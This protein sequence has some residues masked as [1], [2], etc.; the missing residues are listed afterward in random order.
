MMRLSRLADYGV[1]LMTQMARKP[2]LVVNTHDLVEASGLPAATVSKLLATLARHDLLESIR[3]SKGGYLL[4]RPPSAITMEQI[5]TAIDGP[6]S[7]T[8]CVDE[9]GD[10]CGVSSFCVSQTYW[11]RI[12]EAIKDALDQVTLAEIAGSVPAFFAA[13][14]VTA[15]AG[16]QHRKGAT[17]AGGS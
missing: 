9:S 14:E 7:L 5:I 15:P 1:L 11:H 17:G 12:N 6:I 13:G 10:R 3:G 4:A 2:D 8:L 16:D